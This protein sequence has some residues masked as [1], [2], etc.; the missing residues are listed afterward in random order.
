[1]AIVVMLGNMNIVTWYYIQWYNM[2]LSNTL[3]GIYF[4]TK[5]YHLRPTAPS[6]STKHPMRAFG[7]TSQKT[8]AF[9]A[10]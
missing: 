7:V 4:P 8:K 6:L 5:D 3:S 2:C 9:K 10:L 1:M